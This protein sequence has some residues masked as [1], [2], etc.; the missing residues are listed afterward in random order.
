METWLAKAND[1]DTDQLTSTVLKAV[2]FVAEHLLQDKALLLPLVCRI[3]LQAY[4]VPHF[5]SIK[6]LHLTLEVMV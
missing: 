5:G 3:F 2:L 1:E 6:S 4:R